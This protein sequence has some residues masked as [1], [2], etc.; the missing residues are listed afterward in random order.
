MPYRV[1]TGVRGA[2]RVTVSEFATVREAI[3]KVERVARANS[4]GHYWGIVTD[5]D[6]RFVMSANVGSKG[7]VY[8]PAG[9]I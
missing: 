4:T 1:E 5:P 9:L 3:W 7:T 8:N 2:M 6:G